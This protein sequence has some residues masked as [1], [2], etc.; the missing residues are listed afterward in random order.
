MTL[1]LHNIVIGEEKT[2]EKYIK[3]ETENY[4]NNSLSEEFLK[5]SDSFVNFN[6]NKS[7]ENINASDDY[8]Y[9]YSEVFNEQEGNSCHKQSLVSKL[10]QLHEE[11]KNVTIIKNF[12]H[13]N[14]T[15]KLFKYL[16]KVSKFLFSFDEREKLK[17]IEFLSEIDIGLSNECLVAIYKIFSA[18]DREEFWALKCKSRIF[19]TY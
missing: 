4:S 2:T 10:I 12:K 6:H 15:F 13:L 9:D 18:F 17:V 5:S 19:H 7:A 16:R 3:F 11:G 1:L 14:E 8:D